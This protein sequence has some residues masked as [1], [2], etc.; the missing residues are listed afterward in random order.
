MTFLLTASSSYLETKDASEVEYRPWVWI[1]WLFV[2]PTIS[3]IAFDWYIFIATRVLVRAEGLLTQ[4]VFEH[5]LRIRMKAETTASKSTPPSETS[6]PAASLPPSRTVTPSPD[7]AHTIEPSEATLNGSDDGAHSRATTL[8]DS[9]E[10]APKKDA[11]TKGDKKGDEKADEADANLIGKINNLVTTD[12]G[13]ITDSRDFMILIVYT[14]ISV[15]LCITFLYAILGW[16]SLVGLAVII[17][18]MPVPGYLAKLLQDAQVATL[19][20]TDGRVQVI[21]ESA[22]AFLRCGFP[23]MCASRQRPAHGQTLWMGRQ[24]GR[25]RRE[26]T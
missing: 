9:A 18:M 26:E 16:S 11:P 4:L 5:A 22:L 6:T 23:L 21:S 2:G 12:L 10:E 15:V 17:I 24:D 25:A 20:K 3:S 8:Q 13:N 7:G 19:K 14:P 1:V